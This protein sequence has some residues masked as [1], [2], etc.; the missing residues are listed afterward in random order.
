MLLRRDYEILFL[1]NKACF[2]IGMDI[3]SQLK[4]T[5][6][7]YILWTFKDIGILKEVA[8]YCAAFYGM[9]YIK[10]ENFRLRY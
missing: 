8:R 7:K 5:N 10:R 4:N 2:T 6:E 3:I 9:G 1:S